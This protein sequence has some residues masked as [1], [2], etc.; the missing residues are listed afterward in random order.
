MS[1]FSK[2]VI[3]L[4]SV[5]IG[6]SVLVDAGTIPTLGSSRIHEGWTSVLIGSATSWLRENVCSW[7]GACQRSSCG[8][9]KGIWHGSAHDEE[10]SLWDHTES[11]KR[12]I[13]QYVLDHAPLVHLFSAEEFWPCD[14]KDHLLH[15]T[16]HLNYTPLQSQSEHPVL[17]N[18]NELNQWDG[19]FNVYL[20]SNDNV[21]ERPKWLAGRKNIPAKSA[22]AVFD[23]GT[24]EQRPLSSE[25]EKASERRP[26]RSDA[27]A[28]LVVINK[29][30]GIVDAFWF[31]F[32][33]YNL[34]NVVLGA[35]YGNH[36]GDW[37]HTLVRFQHGRPTHVFLSEHYFG[38]AYTYDAV[39]KIGRRVSNGLTLFCMQPLTSQSS[40]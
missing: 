7:S 9:T 30:D 32:Y 19:G 24:P 37:E 31:Y 34:G 40:R 23:S 20:Q 36:V 26:G 22:D 3:A 11:S 6:T 12:D 4:A 38:E 1:A 35:R 8:R 28:V 29:P 14:I 33:S 21:E 15:I 2:I 13:P 25:Q 18:L 39:E 5:H 27:P 10:P 17:T 16:P